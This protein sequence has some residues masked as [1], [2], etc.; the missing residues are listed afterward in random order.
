MLARQDSN[1]S[2]NENKQNNPKAPTSSNDDLFNL[3]EDEA[4]LQGRP[5]KPPL[6]RLFEASREHFSKSLLEPEEDNTTDFDDDDR[7]S[8]DSD[9]DQGTFSDADRDSYDDDYSDGGS[10]VEEEYMYAYGSSFAQARRDANATFNAFN[11]NNNNAGAKNNEIF[12]RRLRGHI[13]RKIL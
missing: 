6:S 7:D 1:D 9:S 3:A 12:R 10:S 8:E 2:A 11:G 5:A 4:S 13:E